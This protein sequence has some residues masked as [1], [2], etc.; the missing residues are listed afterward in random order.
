MSSVGV[1]WLSSA[2]TCLSL[3]V[4]VASVLV[5]P[6]SRWRLIRLPWTWVAATGHDANL[7]EELV[8]LGLDKAEAAT[9][10][11]VGSTPL[12]RHQAGTPLTRSCDVKQELVDAACQET[13]QLVQLQL[14]PP[15]PDQLAVR[16]VCSAPYDDSRASVTIHHA[17]VEVCMHLEH[18]TKLGRLYRAT[19]PLESRTDVKAT[20]ARNAR[21]NER[22]FSMVL[23]YESLSAEASGYQGAL[24]DATFAALARLFGVSHECYAS[25]LNCFFG[26]FCRWV[27]SGV[28]LLA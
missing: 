24:P 6:V 3:A 20:C 18:Y 27:A 10:T 4:R 26:S 17:G 5:M 1:T 14:H 8:E 25:P 11:Q 19:Q 15:L 22:V 23:R 2:V 12:H 28:L 7:L 16:M 9:V 13:K 21:F